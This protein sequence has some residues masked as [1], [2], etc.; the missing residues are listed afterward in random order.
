MLRSLYLVVVAS[1]LGC[2]G[3]HEK[4]EP[5]PLKRIDAVVELDEFESISLGGGDQ[6]GLAPAVHGEVVAAAS[7]S[8]EVYLLNS[9]LDE[10]WDVD[11]G[12]TILGGTA[13]NS[14]N[15]YVITSD[16]VLVALARGD[17]TKVFETVLPVV[18][19][20]HQSLQILWCLSKHRLVVFW[21]LMHRPAQQS[22]LRKRRNQVWAFVA[23]LQ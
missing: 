1:L 17:G 11:L 23:A 14:T 2:S 19:Q 16:A 7:A 4:P 9:E 20:C 15:V 21:Q 5:T 12:R 10:V 18:Q 22:G 3:I 6:T 13:L 8:G